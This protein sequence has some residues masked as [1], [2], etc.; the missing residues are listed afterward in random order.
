MSKLYPNNF[1][2]TSFLQYIILFITAIIIW[3][4]FYP[5]LMSPD[6][7]AQYE[8]AK[9]GIYNDWH[10]PLMS[11]ILRVIITLGGDIGTMILFQCL[12]AIFGLRVV[13]S[14][15]IQFFSKGNIKQPLA[16]VFATILTILFLLPFLTPYTLFSVIFWKDA[17][18]AII[19]LWVISYLLWLIL[20]YDLIYT[21]KFLFHILLFSFTSALTVSIRHN[22]IV[23]LPIICIV[24]GILCKVKIGKIGLFAM[25]L[26]LFFAVSLNPIIYYVFKVTPAYVGNS[27]L[28]SDLVVML[29][30]YPELGPEFP[31]T[32]RR[33]DSPVVL[34]TKD[35]GMWNEITSDKPCPIMN[36]KICDPIMPL[37][38]FG[39][40]E[41]TSNFEGNDCYM[42]VANDNKTLKN[43]Y[44]KA[45]TQHPLSLLKSKLFL[46]GRMLHPD[47]W[48][49][50]KVV[51][52][53]P[54]NTLGV[55]LNDT[56][57]E[58]RDKIC[59]L[60]HVT[61]MNWY[62]N[63]ISGIHVFWFS[64]NIIFLFYFSVKLFFKRTIND[65][66]PLL[67]FLIPFSYYLSYLMA[68]T[69][70]DYRF[71]YPSTLIMQT[72]SVALLIINFPAFLR[73]LINS[74]DKKNVEEFQN[75]KTPVEKANIVLEGLRGKPVFEICKIYKITEEKYIEWHK[76]FIKNAASVFE[77]KSNRE[78]QL[79]EEN[80]KLKS[81][82]EEIKKK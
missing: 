73:F 61:S 1:I 64:L 43:E 58:S 28:A 39:N 80:K 9:S 60:S 44:Y 77:P 40:S 16:N 48:F 63:W 34:L 31:L 67:L 37:S 13:L 18:V 74:P 56:F 72:M 33:K 78:T 71:M 81:L 10:P 76:E 19:S 41:N 12:A 17:W 36:K 53:I 29:R 54:E 62:F 4:I 57:K 24:C 20:N 14:L 42:L 47:N 30:F 66:F 35:G 11:M 7:L 69:T 46:F 38:C 5:G 51:C 27:V 75:Q 6:S 52:D 49:D 23:I 70:P 32:E 68:A 2:K 26:P 65:V 45:I 59:Y 22:S 55:K 3:Q 82:L 15:L 25:A 79:E 21:K 50:P 8:Q